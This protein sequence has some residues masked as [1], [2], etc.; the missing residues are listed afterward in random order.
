MM[1]IPRSCLEKIEFIRI[2]DFK[3]RSMLRSQIKWIN[4]NKL[5]IQNRARNLYYLILNEHATEQLVKRCCDFKLL[6]RK[7]DEFMKE[8]N[9]REEEILYQY[10]YA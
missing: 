1:P 4:Q 6:E 2:K 7:C 9:L 5:R 8:N 3:Y 10:F